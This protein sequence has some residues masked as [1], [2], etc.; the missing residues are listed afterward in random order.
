MPPINPIAATRVTTIR[1]LLKMRPG[2]A[3]ASTGAAKVSGD[4]FRATVG[5]ARRKTTAS[6]SRRDAWVTVV[7]LLC[8][9]D[10][11]GIRRGSDDCRTVR[12]NESALASGRHV[13][14]RRQASI[15]QK[16]RDD[17]ESK[18]SPH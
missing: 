8:A 7:R 11:G 3:K 1:G 18:M 2:A 4:E 14:R 12:R 9:G 13:S 5:T 15:F 6:G 10:C 17:D 16:F